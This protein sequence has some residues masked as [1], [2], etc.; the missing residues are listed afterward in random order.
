VGETGYPSREQLDDE[1]RL[2]Q[3]VVTPRQVMTGE[4]FDRD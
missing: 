1:A 3:A 2:W 4:D